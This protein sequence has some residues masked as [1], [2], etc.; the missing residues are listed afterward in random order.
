MVPSGSDAASA[1]LLD[2]DD[3]PPGVP[4]AAT[5]IELDDDDDNDNT[6]HVPFRYIASDDMVPRQRGRRGGPSP[7]SHAGRK[8]PRQATAHPPLTFM[9][10]GKPP[11][12]PQPTLPGEKGSPLRPDS[13]PSLSHRQGR[14]CVSRLQKRVL[15]QRGDADS[16][17]DSGQSE[18]K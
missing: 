10:V 1:I 16:L 4:A 14:A 11:G 17:A 12:K 7:P 9:Q 2:G 5:V 6:T 18:G 8:A 13:P 15:E 3:S